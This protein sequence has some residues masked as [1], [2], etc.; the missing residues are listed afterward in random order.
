MTEYNNKTITLTFG[1][2]GENHVGME[3]IGEVCEDSEV[4]SCED[5]RKISLELDCQSEYHDLSLDDQ[6]EAGFLI[7]RG[8]FKDLENDLFSQ[9]QK[10]KWDSQYYDTRRNR[11]LNKHA[12]H[13]L[14]FAK[15]VERESDYANKKGS[16]VDMNSIDSLKQLNERLEKSINECTRSKKGSNLICEGNLYFEKKCGIGYHGDA[17]RKKT[18]GC[19][20]GE[21]MNLHFQWFIKHKPIDPDTLHYSYV[22]NSGDVYIMSSKAVGTDWK[23]SSI[24]TLR[25]AGGH[26]NYTSLKKYLK[27]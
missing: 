5:L 27:A 20:I 9:L 23:K 22:L 4:F 7:L 1:D 8:Y 15:G 12:R 17:E 24:P 2:A 26:D 16:I 18:I 3:K 21:S 6:N 14:L 10:L 11:V 13:N 25:H 19:R